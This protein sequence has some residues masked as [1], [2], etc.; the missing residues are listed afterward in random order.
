MR[1]RITASVLTVLCAWVLWE[2]HMSNTGVHEITA[3]QEMGMLLDC[4]KAIPDALKK[5]EVDLQERFK[6]PKYNVVRA[7]D[8]VILSD[9]GKTV[10][11]AYVYYCLPPTVDPYHDPR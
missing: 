6:G 1:V 10:R 4:R 2:K 9:D 3:I 11:H 7:H 8:G 5:A